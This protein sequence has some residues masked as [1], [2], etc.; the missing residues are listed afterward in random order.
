[1]KR[2]QMHFLIALVLSLMLCTGILAGCGSG[3]GGGVGVG[4]NGNKSGDGTE[5][6]LPPA[7]STE[8]SNWDSMEWD[9]GEWG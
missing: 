7:E 1:M 4:E 3:G 5:E 8:G 2:L 6:N 9:Q